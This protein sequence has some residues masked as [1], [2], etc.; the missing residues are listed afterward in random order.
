MWNLA[1]FGNALLPLIEQ[2]EPLEQALDMYREHYQRGWEATL[3]DKLGFDRFEPGTDQALTD[4]LFSVLQLV[5]TDMT[6]FF[7]KLATLEIGQLL[8]GDVDDETLIQPLIDA[9]YDPSQWT[10]AERA[11][12]ATW[13]RTY[14]NRLSKSSTPE[15][16]RRDRMNSVNPKYVLRNFLAQLAID[17]A[18]DDDMSLLNELLEL[19][20]HPY[21]EQ[22]GQDHFAAKRPDWARHRAGCSM[23]SCSS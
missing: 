21:D 11:Q 17:Q 15:T 22:P 9:Y 16:A 1:Q 6:I 7:R 14:G 19:L 12:I 4:E 10:A 5:E 20:R 23:L 18:E 3:A 13:L 2:V 8:E